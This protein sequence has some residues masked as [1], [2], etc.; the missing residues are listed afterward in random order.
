MNIAAA[1]W[2]LGAFLLSDPNT[3]EFNADAARFKTEAACQEA[4]KT[5]AAAAEKNGWD[6]RGVCIDT[7]IPTSPQESS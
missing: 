6:F 5:I 4:N 2:F 3:G 7:D 1:T